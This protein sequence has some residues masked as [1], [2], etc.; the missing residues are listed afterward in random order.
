MRGAQFRA[1]SGACGGRSCVLVPIRLAPA[2]EC[3]VSAWVCEGPGRTEVA[4]D[5]GDPGGMSRREPPPPGR[6]RRHLLPRPVS[7]EHVGPNRPFS[8]FNEGVGQSMKPS[9]PATSCDD[10]ARSLATTGRP[11]A[12]AGGR[13]E[14]AARG[15]RRARGR[16]A[17]LRGGAAR[18]RPRGR[19]RWRGHRPHPRPRQ[20]L[21]DPAVRHGRQARTAIGHPR[22]ARPAGGRAGPRHPAPTPGRRGRGAPLR[23]D[24]RGG[25]C[26]LP[27]LRQSGVRS[28]NQWEFA[29]QDLPERGGRAV[30]SCTRA[31]T[32]HGPGDVLVQFRTSTASATA[33]A[34]AVGRARSTAACS[35]FGQ[36]IVA[37]T[38]W[39][40]ASGRHYLLAAGSREVEEIGV[41]GDVEVTERGRT[42]AVRA[43]R[44]PN[45]TVRARLTDGETLDEVG[46]HPVH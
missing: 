14:R 27:E 15:V 17:G 1:R 43:P 34:K 25:A 30:W 9:V 8:S 11:V 36:H 18:G 42:L 35:R 4:A 2:D 24:R 16:G 19:R 29:E 10:R 7:T 12:S 37:S 33:P 6:C 32:W 23:C 39:T 28:V 46:P 45:A 26:R 5:V 21:G 13:P 3:P 20:G 31:S 38:P 40:A 22:G 41:T 44:S